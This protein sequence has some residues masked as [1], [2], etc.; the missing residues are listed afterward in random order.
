MRNFLTALALAS[1][2]SAVRLEYDSLHYDH[3]IDYYRGEGIELQSDSNFGL[4]VQESAM[5]AANDYLPK[6]Y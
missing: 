5:S 3:E 1:A 2:A 4:N 6:L